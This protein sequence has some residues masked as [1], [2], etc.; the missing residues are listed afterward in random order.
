MSKTKKGLGFGLLALLVLL[1]AG[2]YLSHVNIPVLQP[3]GPVADKE[4][5]LLVTVFLLMLIVV[6]PVFGMLWYIVWRYR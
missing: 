6:I 1:L 4:F 3:R 2:F 5:R